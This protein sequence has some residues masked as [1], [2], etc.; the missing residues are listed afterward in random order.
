MSL[1]GKRV[2]SFV[3]FAVFSITVGCI[4]F[5]VSLSIW[6]V[7]ED[8]SGSGSGFFI[9]LLIVVVPYV[10]IPGAIISGLMV[11]PIINHALKATTR[12]C[13]DYAAFLAAI[14]LSAFVSIVMT[15][16]SAWILMIYFGFPVDEIRDSIFG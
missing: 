7:S 5:L 6:A 14:G 13:L 9:A 3:I 15:Y 1:T 16:I 11:L 12:S 8:P 2:L 10:V 4:F